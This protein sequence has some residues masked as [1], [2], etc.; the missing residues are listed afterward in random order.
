M[1]KEEGEI[2]RRRSERRH[3]G[4]LLPMLAF[5]ET[6]LAAK[7]VASVHGRIMERP[8]DSDSQ[9]SPRTSKLFIMIPI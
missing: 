5:W 7:Q 2:G 8:L 1:E 3:I 4:T 9:C 6:L